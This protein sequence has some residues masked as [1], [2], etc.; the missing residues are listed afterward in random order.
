MVSIPPRQSG[1][2]RDQ[3]EQIE[4]CLMIENVGNDD[5]LIGLSFLEQGIHSQPFEPHTP[6]RPAI[7]RPTNKNPSLV[8]LEFL[9]VFRESVARCL[10]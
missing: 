9:D 3:I 6:R 1:G 10:V 4:P 5:Q 2:L 7:D 8:M